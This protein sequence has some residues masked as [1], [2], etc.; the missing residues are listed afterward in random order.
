MHNYVPPYSPPCESYWQ[1]ILT[2]GPL[3]IGKAPGPWEW[4]EAPEIPLEIW[5]EARERQKHHTIFEL[6]IDDFN[7]GGV[8]AHWNEIECF[9]PASHLVAYPFPADPSARETCFQNYLG[10]VLR[11]CIIEVE[12][13]RNRILLSERQVPECELTQPDWPDWLCIGTTCTGVVT[14]VRPFGAFVDIGPMEGMVHI[15]EMS[16]GRVRQPIDFL[17]PGQ[18]VRVKILNVDLEHQR[19]GLSL[20]RLRENPWTCVEEYFQTGD[21]TAGLIASI[22][23]FGIFVELMEGIEGLLHISELGHTA[24]ADELQNGYETGSTISVRIL[25]IIPKDHR[26]ALGLVEQGS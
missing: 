23:R 25:E 3:S 4:I 22:E 18:E 14:S 20:K 10:K 16:W 24:T 12:P 19:A 26:I 17:K 2:Q 1:S 6:E 7:R 15:S 11:L 5:D 9:V 8:I 13:S 21:I